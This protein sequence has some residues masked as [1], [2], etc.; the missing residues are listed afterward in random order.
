MVLF[1]TV[2]CIAH[3]TTVN[4]TVQ[5]LIKQYNLHSS[6]KHDSKNKRGDNSIFVESAKDMNRLCRIGK[7]PSMLHN[8]ICFDCMLDY[9]NSAT[10]TL[11][12]ELLL[13]CRYLG[14]D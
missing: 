7:G 13:L 8:I 12:S 11:Y 10:K 4:R 5:D 2:D 6:T 3:P 1:I 14:L 9:I